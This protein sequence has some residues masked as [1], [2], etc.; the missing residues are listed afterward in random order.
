MLLKLFPEIMFIPICFKIKVMTFLW[1]EL[2]FSQINAIPFS[3]LGL[4]LVLSIIFASS[5]NLKI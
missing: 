5:L 3:L 1:F 4:Y 2:I